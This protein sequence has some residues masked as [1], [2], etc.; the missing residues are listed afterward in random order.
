MV[1]PVHRDNLSFVKGTGMFPFPLDTLNVPIICLLFSEQMESHLRSFAS[2]I[3]DLPR[4][5]GFAGEFV[6]VPMGL[7]DKWRHSR[8]F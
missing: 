1:L 6:C 8:D 7:F 5:V 4:L 3:N 2:A